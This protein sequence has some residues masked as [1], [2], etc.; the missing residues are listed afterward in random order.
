MKG[1]RMKITIEFDKELQE[2]IQRHL[3]G[4]P[5]VQNYV[6]SALRYFS[7][8]LRI[9]EKGNKCGFGEANRFKQYNSEVSP[10]NYLNGGSNGE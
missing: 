3:N 2:A 7:D 4:G 6:K 9:E 1:E 8:M 5:S 10:T